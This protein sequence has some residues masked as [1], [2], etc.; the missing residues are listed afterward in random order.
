MDAKLQIHFHAMES[1]AA[2]EARIRDR[3]A[4]IERRS[5]EITGC[6]VTV[7]KASRHYVKGNLFRVALVLHRPG[8]DIV[9]SRG[10]P[11]DHGH[12]D[13]Y[14]A[15]RDTFDAAERQLAELTP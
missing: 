8:R 12:E 6:R 10:G 2:L 9:V 1:S 5:R 4:E 11:K 15:V 14:T 3:F 7:E 13:V